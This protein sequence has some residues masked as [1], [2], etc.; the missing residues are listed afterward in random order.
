MTT[1]APIALQR[2]AISTIG[3]ASPMAFTSI[4]GW[5]WNPVI[6]V[7]LLSRAIKMMFAF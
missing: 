2:A 7:P 5:D 3:E 1:G 6:A 4:P